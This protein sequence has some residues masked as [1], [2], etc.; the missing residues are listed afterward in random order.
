MK[1]SNSN[2]FYKNAPQVKH[3]SSKTVFKAKF[4]FSGEY[5]WQ[6]VNICTSSKVYSCITRG[7]TCTVSEEG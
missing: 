5:M 6:I 1:W 2:N 4:N 7:Y 3:R